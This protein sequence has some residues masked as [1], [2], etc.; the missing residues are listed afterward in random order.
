[1]TL[2]P[3]RLRLTTRQAWT[4]STPIT[5]AIGIVAVAA[6][7]ASAAA[8][9]PGVTMTLAARLTRSTASSGSPAL[10]PC[11]QRYSIAMLR[12]STKPASASPLREPVTYFV[13]A[14]GD[15]GW[16]N[17]I[18]GIAACCARATTGHAAAPP[19]S[20]MNSRRFN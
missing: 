8:T 5:K 10:S 9:P 7:A 2:P 16:S 20:V 17:P 11:P 18:A 1:V 3:G 4:G 19:R 12:P 6:L 14:S 13:F 15:P